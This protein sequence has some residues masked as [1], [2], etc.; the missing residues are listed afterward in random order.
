M[1]GQEGRMAR[2]ISKW[3]S[4]RMLGCKDQALLTQLE[5]LEKTVAN[6]RVEMAYGLWATAAVQATEAEATLSAIRLRLSAKNHP[7]RFATKESL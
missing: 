4:G 2:R 7:Q 1:Y 5:A 6:L 3:E